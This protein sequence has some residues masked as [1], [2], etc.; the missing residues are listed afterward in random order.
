MVTWDIF[1]ALVT[2]CADFLALPLTDL[3][4]TISR[5]TIWPLIRKREFVTAIP[6][7]TLPSSLNDMRII[8]CTML[9][10]KVYES[11]VLAW[12]MEEVSIKKN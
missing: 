2:R 10:S 4:N 3:Y 6:K 5:T 9:V 12:A 8:S 7:R 1:P 11:Y